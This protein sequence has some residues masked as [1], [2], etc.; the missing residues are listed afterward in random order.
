[1][2]IEPRSKRDGD[3]PWAPEM[4]AAELENLDR[5][6]C[7]EEHM[8]WDD[9]EWA[10]AECHRTLKALSHMTPEENDDA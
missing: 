8:D 5:K 1:M 3:P 7:E 2:A 4:L 9:I 6:S 10:L